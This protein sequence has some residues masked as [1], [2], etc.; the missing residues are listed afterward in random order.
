MHIKKLITGEEWNIYF[1][2]TYVDNNV[3][4]ETAVNSMSDIINTP[5]L[6]TRLK[7]NQLADLVNKSSDLSPDINW[8]YKRI[9]PRQ[10]GKIR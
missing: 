4:W 9:T 2:E 3:Q 10:P 6:I 1:K 8:N 7:P 5:I